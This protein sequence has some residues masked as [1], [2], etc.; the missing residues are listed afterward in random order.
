MTIL[1]SVLSGLAA[2]GALWIAGW[3]DL[4]DVAWALAVLVALIPL[5]ITVAR[6]LLNRKT[7][8]DLIALLAMSGSLVLD[9]Y[10]AGAV[11]GLM[12]SG[13]QAL[14]HYAS[15]RAR[16]ELSALISRAPRVVHRYEDGRLTEPDIKDVKR[17]S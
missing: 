10:L 15:G 17:G 14:E 4:A 6:D 12:L 3:R 5:S 9:Q 8:V 16:R 1:V 11:I 13:G 7:G 2:G